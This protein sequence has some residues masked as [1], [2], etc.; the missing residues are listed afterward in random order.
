VCGSGNKAFTYVHPN[1]LN[2][3]YE[4][5]VFGVHLNAEVCDNLDLQSVILSVRF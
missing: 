4:W 1:Y 2:S 3:F 5:L